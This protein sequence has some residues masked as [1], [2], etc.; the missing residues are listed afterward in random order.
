MICPRKLIALGIVLIKTSYQ[1]PGYQLVRIII[2][3]NISHRVM[4][5]RMKHGHNAHKVFVDAVDPVDVIQLVQHRRLSTGYILPLH[6]GLIVGL[7]KINSGKIICH[8]L[9]GKKSC[10][11]PDLCKSLVTQCIPPSQKY[12]CRNGTMCGVIPYL[13]SASNTCLL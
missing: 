9:L 12:L 11:V 13:S 2:S 3:N 5:P 7:A 1:T 10:I 4:I 8:D 6:C